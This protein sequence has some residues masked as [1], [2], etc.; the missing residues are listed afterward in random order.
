MSNLH[1]FVGDHGDLDGG[2]P[3]GVLSP[4]NLQLVRQDDPLVPVLPDGLTA[5]CCCA[6]PLVRLAHQAQ[7]QLT[8]SNLQLTG[9]LLFTTVILITGRSKC[10]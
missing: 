9:R 2:V 4:R 3:Q 7:R 10:M 8:R 1:L 5:G 6:V